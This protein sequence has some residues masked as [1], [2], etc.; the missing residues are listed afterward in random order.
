MEMIIMAVV[1]ALIGPVADT[2]TKWHESNNTTAIN[3]LQLEN[4]L[5]KVMTDAALN[6]WKSSNDAAWHVFDSFQQSLRASAQVRRVW[7]IA[8]YSQ[9]L[10]ILYLEVGV[11]LLVGLGT[12]R[13]WPVGSLDTWA[14]GFLGA[15]LG[16][17]PII[18][19]AP[20][21]PGTV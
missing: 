16:I 12:I 18:M 1:K 9:L 21:P 7:S 14:L 11:P 4:D 17:A 3:R 13:S 19:K 8:V 10:F 20:K 6:A 2:V 5:K 15:S